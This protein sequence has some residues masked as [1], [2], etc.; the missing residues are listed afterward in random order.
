MIYKIDQSGKVEDIG[1]DTVLA[2][3]NGQ[4]F[5][6]KITAR[7]KIALKQMFGK[8]NRGK[9]YVYKIFSILIYL[10][11]TNCCFKVREVIVDEEYS[12]QDRL[13]KDMLSQLFTNNRKE[14]PEIYFARIGNRPKVHYAAYNVFTRKIKANRVFSL[15]EIM[16][17]TTKKDRGLK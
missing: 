4:S 16:N 8:S 2:I 17:L 6:I 12:G 11:I 14:M 15:R 3:S 13:I 5:A 9:V 1:K 7:T 10:L